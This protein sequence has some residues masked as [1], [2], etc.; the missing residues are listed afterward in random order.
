MK[1][2]LQISMVAMLLMVIFT[3]Q[4][5]AYQD[6]VYF[7]A[8]LTP[9]NAGLSGWATKATATGSVAK[10]GISTLEGQ[11]IY[12]VRKSD[13]DFATL[14]LRLPTSIGVYD[15]EYEKDGSGNSLGRNGYN[16]RLNIARYSSDTGGVKTTDGWFQ[17]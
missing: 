1:K 9:G 2:L 17:P 15:K 7:E 10:I 8:S 16:Y 3:S 13:G 11:W 14:Q 12:R 6:W 5:F 4:A